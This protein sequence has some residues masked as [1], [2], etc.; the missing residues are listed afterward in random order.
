[1][2][3]TTVSVERK[4]R[5]TPEQL[6]P[7]ITDLPRMGEWSP[8]ATGGEWLDDKQSADLGARFKG[9]NRNGSKSWS[10]VATVT[11]FEP[12]RLF[13]F[14][15]TAAVPIAVW[16]YALVPTDD[17]GTLVTETWTDQRNGLIKLLGKPF[18]GVADRVTHNRANMETTLSRLAEVAE[19]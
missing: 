11:A 1:M 19:A 17:G 2:T 16:S 7:L 5:A 3:S 6:F 8:E 9:N 18:S 10:T 12:N 4:I 13:S 15:I 14:R